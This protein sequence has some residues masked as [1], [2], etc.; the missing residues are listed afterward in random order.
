MTCP[1]C[2]RYVPCGSRCELD[3]PF[4]GAILMADGATIRESLIVPLVDEE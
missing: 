2:G 1:N 4:C 3:C